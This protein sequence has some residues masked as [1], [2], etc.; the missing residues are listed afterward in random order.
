MRGCKH[1]MKP[2]DEAIRKRGY[3]KNPKTF[4][5]EVSFFYTNFN[6]KMNENPINVLL[7]KETYFDL[8]V[9]HGTIKVP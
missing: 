2:Q 1:K 3:V 8:S 9:C 4:I 6:P 5:N 7:K